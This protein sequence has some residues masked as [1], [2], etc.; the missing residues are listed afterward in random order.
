MSVLYEVAGGVARVILNRPE[1]LNALDLAVISRLREVFAAAAADEVR[2]VLLTGSGRAFCAG[3]DVKAMLGMED[4]ASRQ[5]AMLDAV[6][7][8]HRMLASLY[9]L[10]KPV[11]AAVNG[12]AA[13]AGVGLALACDVAWAARS[14]T[15]TLA[16]TGIGVS[17]DSGTTYLLPRAV[18]PR[19]ASELLLTNRRL[20]AEEALAA[21]LVTRVVDD[22]ELEGLAGKLAARLARGPTR[23]YARTKE[24]LRRSFADR[25]EAQL[26]NE[27]QEVGRSAVTDDFVE[28]L[29]AFVEKRRPEFRGE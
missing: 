13:G 10:P 2:A 25:F 4:A 17:P 29:R 20:S 23:A 3:G 14:A 1:A 8:L 22:G 27:R 28:G 11:V 24:L 19:L 15:F 18:G 9:L 26:E 6:G 5:E 12:A 7:E 21:G 16:F